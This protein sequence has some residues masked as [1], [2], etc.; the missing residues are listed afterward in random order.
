LVRVHRLTW[1]EAHGQIP[2]DKIVMHTCDNPPC[3]RLDHLVLGTHKTNSDDKFAKGRA[4]TLRGEATGRARLTEG[5]VFEVLQ[6]LQE[7]QSQRSIARHFDVSPGAIQGIADGRNWKHL[8]QPPLGN[9]MHLED[10]RVEGMVR[11]SGDDGCIP[12]HQVLGSEPSVCRGFFD[13]H[14]NAI[15]QIAERLDVVEFTEVPTKG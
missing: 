9:L 13:K 6:R 7:G 4:N 14:K 8:I 2:A 10:G 3:Y 1:Q 12:C 5:Q 11:D 15:L